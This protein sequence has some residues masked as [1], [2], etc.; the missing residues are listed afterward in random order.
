M[1]SHG[2]KLIV[3]LTSALLFTFFVYALFQPGILTLTI[4]Y[5]INALSQWWLM[6]WISGVEDEEGNPL[7]MRI[8]ARAFLLFIPAFYVLGSLLVA[9]IMVAYLIGHIFMG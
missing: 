5:S 2:P 7:W 9:A 1:N 4:A 8:P 3:L 6:R